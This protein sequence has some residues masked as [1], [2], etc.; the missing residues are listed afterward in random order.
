MAS[1]PQGA[2][3]SVRHWRMLK[4]LDLPCLEKF[5]ALADPKESKIDMQEVHFT[6]WSNANGHKCSGMRFRDSDLEHGVVRAVKPGAWIS[7]R[8]C[9]DGKI[10][11]LNRTIDK[12]SV[13]VSLNRDGTEI[14]YFVFGKS[15]AMG[16]MES[17]RGGPNAELLAPFK[18]NFFIKRA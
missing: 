2:N 8:T 17:E 13:R 5:W 18:P 12:D 6:T 4:P 14:A 15:K 3:D 11:G 16:W 9:R 7:E 10:H 1:V